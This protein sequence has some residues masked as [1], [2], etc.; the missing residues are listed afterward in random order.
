MK[1]SLNKYKTTYIVHIEESSELFI[2][3]SKIEKTG[4]FLVSIAFK[5]F[6]VSCVHE[7]LIIAYNSCIGDLA[8]KVENRE[9]MLIDF[10]ADVGV[11]IEIMTK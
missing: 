9:D 2:V 8:N 10:F 7:K 1:I 3:I 4:N 6:L 5:S 11:I